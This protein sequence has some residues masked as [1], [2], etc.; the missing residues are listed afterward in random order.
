MKYRMGLIVGLVMFRVAAFA[1]I[2]VPGA[3]N[4]DGTLHVVSNATVVV[5]LAQAVSGDWDAD[6]AANAGSGVYD[7]NKW[8]V[9]YKYSSVT[10]DHGATLSFANH[11]SR[12]PVVWLVDGDV[13]IDGTIS[14]NG[15]H[16]VSAPDLAEP[17]P[18]GFRGAMGY[19]TP[20]VGASA[21]FGPG[22]GYTEVTGQGRGAS[23][24]NTVTSSPIAY[25]NPSIVPL[26]GGS[27]GGGTSAARGG[28]AGGGAILIAC[29]GTLQING[30][31]RSNGGNGHDQYSTGADSG[32]G[33]GGG[34][35]LVADTFTGTGQVEA[36]GGIGAERFGSLGRVRM[37]RV[38]NNNT[39]TAI[40]PDPSVV[41]LP[42][43]DTALLW[44]TAT[45]PT[46]TVISI[47]SE[48]VPG[49]PMASFG[50]VGADVALA[51]TNTTRVVIETTYVE[52]ASAVTVRV[53]PRSNANYTEV[54]AS[55][56]EEISSDP[57]TIRWIADIP[58]NVGYSAIQVHV[59]RP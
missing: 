17:G 22:G 58:V 50:T 31:I 47:G 33:S 14:L 29:S 16:W 27:G 37:E 59:V 13:T 56:D 51:Q 7:S 3:D 44:P 24:A 9:V 48:N 11:L 55:V 49:D 1:A 4:S 43:G 45:A 2:T 39:W 54:A 21:G 8:A 15:E 35:R 52:Q 46:V 53:T 12:A 30:I 40:A 6:N 41:G 5:D 26:L 25:G 19:Y 28:G 36:R 18:G 32:S 23:H 57:L 10:I 42:A 20:G 34:I 38:V